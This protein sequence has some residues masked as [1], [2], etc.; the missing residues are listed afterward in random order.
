MSR[1]KQHLTIT[2]EA[3]SIH[4]LVMEAINSV[5]SNKSS[6]KLFKTD[7]T[8]KPFNCIRESSKPLDK[9]HPSSEEQGFYLVKKQ[10]NPSF[11]PKCLDCGGISL[12]I[13]CQYSYY[14]PCCKTERTHAMVLI[15]KDHR[16]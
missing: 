5:R 16:K 9:H 7:G 10:M 14:C 3:V 2:E 4:P 8:A 15:L 6:T 13:R 11:R 12:M 1:I